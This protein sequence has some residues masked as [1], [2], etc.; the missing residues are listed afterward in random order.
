MN[1]LTD[2]MRSTGNV[3]LFLRHLPA[4][5]TETA[6][7]DLLWSAI[8][9]NCPPEFLS[10]KD[11]DAGHAANSLMLLNRDVLADFFN[12]ALFDRGL[13]VQPHDVNKQQAVGS[14]RTYRYS[15]GQR[16]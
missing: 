15:R 9:L 8:G 2:K 6:L 5:I 12:R 10:C 11:T 14:D 3:V 4:G 13:T 16:P 7:A 1:D